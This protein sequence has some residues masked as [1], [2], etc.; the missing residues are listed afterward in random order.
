MPNRRLRAIKGIKLTHAELDDNFKRTVVAKAANDTIDASNNHEIWEANGTGTLTFTLADAAT[1]L[2]ACE[3][4]D[5]R[6]TVHNPTSHN[7]IIDTA[8]ADTI[9]ARN[10]VTLNK[11]M[12]QSITIGINNAG[13]GFIMLDGSGLSHDTFLSPNMHIVGWNPLMRF[14]D[15]DADANKSIIEHTYQNGA[16]AINFWNDD[17]DTAKTAIDIDFDGSDVATIDLLANVV[18]INGNGIA[19]LAA[20]TFTGTQTIN[21]ASPQI[22]MLDITSGGKFQ[23]TNF[24]EKWRLRADLDADGS[25]ETS[26]LVVDPAL[27][28]VE[29]FGQI[30]TKDP[31]GGFVGGSY[32]QIEDE[33][34]A[35]DNPF[36]IAPTVGA[37]WWSL[38]PTGSGANS[39]WS[40]L[41]SIP[42][43][44]KWLDLGFV[45]SSTILTA[46]ETVIS[47]YG[48]KFSS[49]LTASDRTTIARV[50]A[51]HSGSSHTAKV[52]QTYR[53][54]I[55]TG[56][57]V[58]MFS[59]YVNKI[60]DLFTADMYLLG[61]G[62]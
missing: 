42:D 29:G 56:G 4:G 13:D 38:G 20:N 48:R 7:V 35:K 59:L 27:N 5:F 22:R 26:C 40:T 39:V 21:A 16:Y 52:Y 44:A 61:F 24:L 3:T 55:D 19:G 54:P 25:Y 47:V 53:L 49:T 62:E 50:G 31:T 11:D 18:T 1:V 41:D 28:K 8:T 60:G 15:T 58:P 36:S 6:I 37:S 9:G 46:G 14:E 10:T 32:T 34:G 51:T 43:G 17:Y 30:L 12:N 33:C 57:G 23:M 2:A 45:M